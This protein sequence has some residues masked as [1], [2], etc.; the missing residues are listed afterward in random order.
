MQAM[1]AA[2][3]PTWLRGAKLEAPRPER[4]GFFLFLNTVGNFLIIDLPK[5]LQINGRVFPC[6]TDGSL[7][8]V[9]FVPVSGPAFFCL[10]ELFGSTEV[11]A[12]YALPQL[13]QLLQQL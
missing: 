10:T 1:I 5:R 8:I 9:F 6:S 12:P 13:I 7:S 3:S 4:S 11:P 2:F